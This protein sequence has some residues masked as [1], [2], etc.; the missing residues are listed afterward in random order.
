MGTVALRL[1]VQSGGEPLV[2]DEIRYQNEADNFYSVTRFNFLMTQIA[3]SGSGGTARVT[4][5]CE[6]S[7]RRAAHRKWMFAP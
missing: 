2:Y 5:N 1:S 4:A 7:H 3:L 6:G